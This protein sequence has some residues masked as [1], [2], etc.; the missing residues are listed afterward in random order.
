MKAML[1]ARMV[2]DSTHTPWFWLHGWSAMRERM[3]ASSHGTFMGAIDVLTEE[4]ASLSDFNQGTF[5]PVSG[6]IAGTRVPK[7][8]WPSDPSGRSH[9][10][11]NAVTNL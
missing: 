4:T 6:A 3:T 2:A 7:K 11:F 9:S 1:E 5:V 10:F 8:C